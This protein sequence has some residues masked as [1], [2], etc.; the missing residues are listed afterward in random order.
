MAGDAEN[1]E[2]ILFKDFKR[3]FKR[4]N[5]I[6][7]VVGIIVGAVPTVFFMAVVFDIDLLPRVSLWAGL[8]YGTQHT[9]PRPALFSYETWADALESG[10]YSLTDIPTLIKAALM[11]GGYIF[12]VLLLMKLAN[13]LQPPIKEEEKS[14]EDLL[15]AI[16]ETLKEK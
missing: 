8:D 6:D 4:D 10:L 9:P 2:V 3:F 14:L 5:L 15:A 11:L 16:R 13:W 1:K 12:G 7:F